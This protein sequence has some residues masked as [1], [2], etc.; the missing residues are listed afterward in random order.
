MR[1]ST[2]DRSSTPQLSGFSFHRLFEDRATGRISR[3][4]QF[5]AMMNFAQPGDTVVVQS[6]D[7]LAR[8]LKDLNTSVHRL[9][10]NGVRVEFVKEQLTFAAD[11]E[12]LS[13]VMLKMI[14]AFAEFEVELVRERQ[15]EGVTLAKQRGAYR[16][17]IRALAP[18]RIAEL[19]ERAAAGVPKTILATE[20]G[21]S[22]ETVYAY[23]RDPAPTSLD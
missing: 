19:Q 23:L 3:Q 5:E 12:T 8:N 1:T 17:R 6:M 16:G 9:T 7:R 11:D 2:L 13:T 18:A 4:S 14:T 20:Y 21:I 22:R 15:R 10:S